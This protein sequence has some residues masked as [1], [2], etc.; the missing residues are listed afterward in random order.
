MHLISPNILPK[1]VPK[2][3]DLDLPP[4][5]VWPWARPPS[6]GCKQC[7][8]QEGW[9]CPPSTFCWGWWAE[10]LRRLAPL[11][12]VVLSGCRRCAFRVRPCPAPR[13]AVGLDL[14]L[15]SEHLDLGL[16]VSPAEQAGTGSVL[17]EPGMVDKV[18]VP[19]GGVWLDNY[20][21][22]SS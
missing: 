5:G 2:A 3:L 11:P 12:S 21:T 13:S 15:V 20:L 19:H 6:A 22:Q 7:C 18:L 4:S 9:Q 14:G 1:I 16:V 17:K 8:R 10:Y